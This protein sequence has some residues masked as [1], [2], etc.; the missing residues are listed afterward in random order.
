MK[1]KLF[2]LT[3][4][5]LLTLTGLRGQFSGSYANATSTIGL[6]FKPVGQEWH[7]VLSVTGGSFAMKATVRGQEMTGTIYGNDGPVA[8]TAQLVNNA[9]AFQSSGFSDNFFRISQEHGLQGIDLTAFMV[10][11]P[12]QVAAPAS[13]G[14]DYDYGYSQ[15]STGQASEQYDRYPRANRAAN[16]YPVLQDAELRKLVAGSQVVIYQRTSYVSDQVASS[17]TY[18]NFCADGTFT[19]N[20]DGSFSVEGYYGGNAQGASHGRNSGTWELVTVQG[21]PSVFM[22]YNNGNTSVNAMNKQRIYQ[23]RWRIGNTQYA[24]QRNKV[25]CN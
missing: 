3:L 19:V 11:D 7:G 13:S 9:M 21:K 2:L 17:I 15:T 12:S 23:G 25:R 18:I 16:P 8:F 24:I 6:Q 20:Y 10:K 14:G 5:T 1:T 4:I 22:A